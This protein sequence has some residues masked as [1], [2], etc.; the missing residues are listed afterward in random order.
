MSKKHRP[1]ISDPLEAAKVAQFE[2]PDDGEVEEDPMD[3]AVETSAAPAMPL[4]P[5][6]KRAP[7]YR[8]L[9]DAKL[10]LGTSAIVIRKDKIVSAEDG[11]AVMN[12]LLASNTPM[13]LIA[14]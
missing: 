12:L 8:V 2:M 3:A 14:D 10:F 9:A 7:R 1:V 11:E 6:S 5:P 4:P 13:E